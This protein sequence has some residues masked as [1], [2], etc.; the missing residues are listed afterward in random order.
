[1]TSM[2]MEEFG[3]IAVDIFN[4]RKVE[5]V[6]A[7]D[8]DEPE[9]V[10]GIKLEADGLVL[11]TDPLAEKPPEAIIGLALTMTVL[12]AKETVGGVPATLLYFGNTSDPKQYVVKLNPLEYAISDPAYTKNVIVYA[13]RSEANM[14]SAQEKLDAEEEQDDPTDEA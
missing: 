7:G 9:C 13:Q 6:F 12:G 10:W 3:P 4:G 11:N 5:K 14:P 8:S 1:M 2:S